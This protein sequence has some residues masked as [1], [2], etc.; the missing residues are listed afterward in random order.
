MQNESGDQYDLV[1]ILIEQ[2]THFARS[3]TYTKIYKAYSLSKKK[4]IDEKINTLK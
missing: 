4:K 1:F 2:M 3:V